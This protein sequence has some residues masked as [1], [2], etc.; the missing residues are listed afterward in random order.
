[1]LLIGLC[2]GVALERGGASSAAPSLL[3]GSRS[4]NDTLSLGDV[5]AAAASSATLAAS[6]ASR[7][8]VASPGPALPR[9]AG[10][11]SRRV[12]LARSAG[13]ADF[14]PLESL[15]YPYV[16]ESPSALPRPPVWRLEL[17]SGPDAQLPA[18]A[19]AAAAGAGATLLRGVL[20]GLPPASAPSACAPAEACAGAFVVTRLVGCPFAE[21]G[22]GGGGAC[23]SSRLSGGDARPAACGAPPFAGTP[24]A[25]AIEDAWEVGPDELYVRLE[26]AEFLA[27]RCV[28]VGACVYMCPFRVTIPGTYRIIAVGL[29]A[30]WAALSELS[31]FPPLIRDNIAGDKLLVSFGDGRGG[32]GGVGG[33]AVAEAAR[34]ATISAARCESGAASSA[35]PVLH[36]CKDTNVPGRWVRRVSTEGL[37]APV[38]PPWLPLLQEYPEEGPTNASKGL[39]IRF[40]TRLDSELTWLPYACCRCELKPA[41]AATC[42]DG[43]GLSFYGDSHSRVFFNGIMRFACGIEGAAP[44]HHW[45]SACA[46]DVAAC[47]AATHPA[48]YT[49]D[50]RAEIRFSWASYG[51]EAAG[52]IVLNFGQHWPNE[53]HGTLD[54]YEAHLQ[55]YFAGLEA[56]LAPAGF[57]VWLETHPLPVITFPYI[58]DV[59]DWR[60][61]PRLHLYNAA[62]DRTL[63]PLVALGKIALV[64]TFDLLLPM[65]DI[66]PDRAHFDLPHAQYALMQSFFGALC[67]NSTTTRC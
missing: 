1:M 46:P 6:V 56:S 63:E 3:K 57:F 33:D 22:E 52:H 36:P 25:D 9:A 65:A 43:G 62:A 19:A 47:P 59:A 61:E 4:G 41:A 38:S 40:F 60:T 32:D 58:Y 45:G 27:L 64:R 17:C 50:P 29:R 28:H 55:N 12:L 44:K 14:W 5:P 20:R 34:A 7:S 31:G 35:A 30:N 54:A 51:A 8:P 11:C 23:V 42:F 39:G 26:G 24:S 66:S 67:P 49:W 15:P 53:K 21:A 18:A 37:F 13:A 10:Q 2:A 16:R 48:C